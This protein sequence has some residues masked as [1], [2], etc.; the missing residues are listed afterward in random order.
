MRC[1]LA[2]ALHRATIAFAITGHLYI[3]QHPAPLDQRQNALSAGGW[4]AL[5]ND[6]QVNGSHWIDTQFNPF[7][8]NQKIITASKWASTAVEGAAGIHFRQQL[9]ALHLLS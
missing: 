6:Y 5:D 9:D 2:L 3:F 7:E 8:H 4:L 1:V